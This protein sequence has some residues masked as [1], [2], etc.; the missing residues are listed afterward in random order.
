MF[1]FRYHKGG[2]AESMKTV[3]GF[4][5]KEGLIADI[6]KGLDRFGGHELDASNIEVKSY[7]FDSR[8]GWD[9][10]MVFIEGYGPIGFT[11]GPIE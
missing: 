4:N 11:N 10:H 2:L 3:K 6:Q 5:S 9:T 1:L 8:I 7:G